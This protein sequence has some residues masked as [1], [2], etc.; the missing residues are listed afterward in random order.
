M[1]KLL[2][3]LLLF[4]FTMQLTSACDSSFIGK[5]RRSL[6][7]IANKMKITKELP[8][9]QCS[10]VSDSFRNN[11]AD[12]MSS[13]ELVQIRLLNIDKKKEAKIIGETLA[14]ELDCLL[15]QVVGHT[16]LLYKEA[17]PKGK[18]TKLLELAIESNRD[19]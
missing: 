18:I 13:L 11:L 15:A 14:E 8:T 9:L 1:S 16:I 19:E 6:R 12:V 17:K 5:H 10:E 3:Y 2:H 4:T 7:S